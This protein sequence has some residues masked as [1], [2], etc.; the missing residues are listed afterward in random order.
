[1]PATDQAKLIAKEITIK[2]IE[3]M[4]VPARGGSGQDI[5]QY[6]QRISELYKIIAKAVDEA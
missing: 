1:M 6:A 4:I 5:E 2:A 3:K